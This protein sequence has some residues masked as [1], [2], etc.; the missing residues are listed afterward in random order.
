MELVNVASQRLISQSE[1]ISIAT[2]KYLSI[3]QAIYRKSYI[4]GVRSI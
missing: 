2:A 1:D 4:Y 3:L